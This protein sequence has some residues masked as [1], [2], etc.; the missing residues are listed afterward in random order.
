MTCACQAPGKPFAI[1]RYHNVYGP[2][3]GSEHVIPELFQRAVGGQSPLTVYS[4]DHRRAF[5]Y[6][7]DAVEATVAA[8]RDPA[9]TATI[10]IGNDR[11]ETLIG[12]LAER[13]LR[14]RANLRASGHLPAGKRRATR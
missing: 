4:A 9:D 3:M 8:M 6:V 11:E 1:V 14:S 2:R 7:S 13:L 12:D 10:N 5:C